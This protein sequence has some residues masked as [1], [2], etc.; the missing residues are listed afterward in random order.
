MC[1]PPS[2]HNAIAYFDKLPPE[3]LA[4]IFDLLRVSDPP[5]YV[6]LGRRIKVP[7]TGWILVTYVCQ[8]WRSVA[9]GDPRLWV[10][11]PFFLGPAWTQEF[12]RR[13]QTVPISLECELIYP[14]PAAKS[15]IELATLFQHH[16]SRMKTVLVEGAASDLDP[17]VPS[18]R[19]AAPALER[20]VIN[21]ND[22]HQLRQL[23]ADLFNGIA[24]RLR[25]MFIQRF[26]FLWSSLTFGSLVELHLSRWGDGTVRSS[27]EQQTFEQFLLALSTMPGL[28]SLGL[29]SVLPPLPVDSTLDSPNLPCVTLSQL[30]TFDLSD[31]DAL[32][33]LVTLKH[34]TTPSATSHNVTF[35][36]PAA[37]GRDI[38]Q[39]SSWFLS[40]VCALPSSAPLLTFTLFETGFTIRWD[41]SCTDAGDS[42][43]THELTLFGTGSIN[44]SLAELKTICQ[45][46]PLSRLTEVR[47]DV[48]PEVS[49][50]VEEWLSI[51]GKCKN[52]RRLEIRDYCPASLLQAL[53]SE[54]PLEGHSGPLFPSL[55][56]LTLGSIDLEGEQA[57]CEELAKWLPFRQTLDPLRTFNFED[58]APVPDELLHKLRDVIPEVQCIGED[59][60]SRCS[61]FESEDDTSISGDE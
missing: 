38:G 17:M 26:D 29:D 20:F 43:P 39:A 37:S 61:C 18:F 59:W 11:I 8:R 24:P 25:F 58:C 46:L 2:R 34:V 35:R 57:M 54:N 14:K 9:L 47:A 21:N 36:Y 60:D 48:D 32:K 42:E 3:D 49:W 13:S 12:L 50:S 27:F 51:F 55:Y 1:S 23:P 44:E 19:M 22:S 5:R 10:D 56:S 41:S 33:C 40:R 7:C 45:R 31:N 52:V 15:I 28:Q 6:R 53:A 16:F 4:Y 30:R